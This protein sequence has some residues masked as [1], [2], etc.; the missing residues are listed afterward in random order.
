MQLAS[1]LSEK[2]GTLTHFIR[3]AQ[4]VLPAQYRPISTEERQSLNEKVDQIWDD[5]FNS[6]LGFGFHEPARPTLSVSAEEREKIF[7]ELWDLG[8]GFRFMFGGFNDIGGDEAA[9]KEAI[10]FIHRK[11]KEIVKDPK[12]AEVLTSSDW[13]A[14][15]PLTDD[16]YYERFNQDNVFAVD[17]KKNPVKELTETGI[18]LEDGTDYPL[19]LIVFATGFDAADGSYHHIDFKGIDGKTLRDRWKNGPETHTGFTT[20]GFP[21][22]LFVN[23]PGVPFANQVPTVEIAADFVAD[24]IGHA[25]DVRLRGQGSGVIESTPEADLKWLNACKQVAEQTLFAR[26]DSWFFG[27]NIPGKTKS[28]LFWFGG[29]A[30]W[31]KAIANTKEKG[32]EGFSFG[33][34]GP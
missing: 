10:N 22:L 26:T 19:D 33:L 29:I 16:N 17:I 20:S 3:H 23:G 32:Y 2:A 31:R 1:A 14:R 6:A 8:S 18:R 11:I 34:P 27:E 21:N 7:Q 30:E 24:L 15:R 28:P 13:F 25:E 5:I 9:N 12:K 4:Y